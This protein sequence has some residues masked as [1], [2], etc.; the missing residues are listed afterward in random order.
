MEAHYR[1]TFMISSARTAKLWS[2]LLSWQDDVDVASPEKRI[3]ARLTPANLW[4]SYL[5]SLWISDKTPLFFPFLS[6]CQQV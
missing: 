2:Q 3:T 1:Q 6:L 5:A 4:C